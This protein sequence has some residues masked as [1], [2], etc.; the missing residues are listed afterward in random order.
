MQKKYTSK[1]TINMFLILFILSEIILLTSS[2]SILSVPNS[3]ISVEVIGYWDSDLPFQ[4]PVE[5]PDNCTSYIPITFDAGFPYTSV[6]FRIIYNGI[7]EIKILRAIVW[8]EITWWDCTWNWTTPKSLTVNQRI[9]SGSYFDFAITDRSFILDQSNTIIF[10]QIE[11]EY[12]GVIY[13]TKLEVEIS[14]NLTNY[15]SWT[16]DQGVA[17]DISFLLLSLLGIIL[18]LRRHLMKR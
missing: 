5:T 15:Q 17:A 12:Q 8:E 9:Q 2:G 14:P 13:R 1:K 10:T 3:E 18:W 6:V 4:Y 16:S 7:G 11:W